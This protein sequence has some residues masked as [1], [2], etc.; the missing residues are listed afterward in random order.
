M[1]YHLSSLITRYILLIFLYIYYVP[2][3]ALPSAS[4]VQRFIKRYIL[5]LIESSRSAPLVKEDSSITLNSFSVNRPNKGS[6]MDRR[7][8]GLAIFYR[9][10]SAHLYHFLLCVRYKKYSKRVYILY[11]VVPCVVFSIDDQHYKRY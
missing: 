8:A 7:K 11:F 3:P 5:I 10:T 2:K 4:N 1:N 9:K 6:G